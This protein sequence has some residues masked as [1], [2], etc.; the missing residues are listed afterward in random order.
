MRNSKN[1][2]ENMIMALS[3]ESILD[4]GRVQKILK[5][6]GAMVRVRMV[7]LNRRFLPKIQPLKN[8]L[9]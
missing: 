1:S 3:M 5:M 6:W 2:S 9:K 7:I 4:E 8:L